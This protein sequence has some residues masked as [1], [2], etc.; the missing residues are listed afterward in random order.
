MRTN[1]CIFKKF[2]DED[3]FIRSRFKFCDFYSQNRIYLAF[4]ST[5]LFHIGSESRN[6]DQ[7]WSVVAEITG[8]YWAHALNEERRPTFKIAVAESRGG[9]FSTVVGD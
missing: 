5:Q 4:M 9:S 1:C 3:P 7:K 8:K 2:M 6:R